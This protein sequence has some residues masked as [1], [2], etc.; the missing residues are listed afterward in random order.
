MESKKGKKNKSSQEYPLMREA[1]GQLMTSEALEKGVIPAVAVPFSEKS[2]ELA[3]R[4]SKLKAIEQIGIRFLLVKEDG[5]VVIV[6]RDNLKWTPEM[7]AALNQN[8][9]M[10]RL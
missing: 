4:W 7:A 2:Y 3:T 6:G 5:D 10:E 8:M 1:I 9:G